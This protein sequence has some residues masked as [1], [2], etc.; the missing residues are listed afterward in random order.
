MAVGAF[1]IADSFLGI[2]G[3]AVDT[4]FLCFCVDCD[5]NDGVNKPYFMSKGLM[6]SD[7]T[8][9]RL[10]KG[11]NQGLKSFWARVWL[12]DIRIPSFHVSRAF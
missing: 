11:T 7:E 5:E 8:K 2:F 9:M 1:I 6:V 12:G 10:V 3:I 4:L